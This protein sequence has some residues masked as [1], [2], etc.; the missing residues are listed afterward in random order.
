DKFAQY[1][2]EGKI[3]A[4]ENVT[5]ALYESAVYDKSVPAQI[6]FL[7][8]KGKQ[9]G[10]PFADIQQ[11]ESSISLQDIMSNAKGRLIVGEKVQ[12]RIEEAQVLCQEDAEIKDNDK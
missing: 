12:G 10:N 4:I 8:N 1:I 9:A 3:E 6:F 2:R 7:K 5:N 11:V